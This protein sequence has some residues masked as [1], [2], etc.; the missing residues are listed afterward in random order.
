MPPTKKGKQK[1]E[2]RARHQEAEHDR[3]TPKAKYSKDDE[4]DEDEGWFTDKAPG[5][6]GGEEPQDDGQD[7][8]DAGGD[9]AGGVG[10][11]GSGIP[12]TIYAGHHGWKVVK[13]TFSKIFFHGFPNKNDNITNSETE[14]K[15]VKA[16]HAVASKHFAEVETHWYN[17]PLDQLVMYVDK[18]QI[19][20]YA[21][22]SYGMRVTGGAV[23]LSNWTILNDSVKTTGGVT[24][25]IVVPTNM[26]WFMIME[27]KGFRMPYYKSSP[28]N[29]EGTV[30][31]PNDRAN[32]ILS[33]I[34]FVVNRPGKW[35]EADYRRLTEPT[36]RPDVTVR[37]MHCS[38]KKWSTSWDYEEGWKL[39]V[40]EAASA[41]FPWPLDPRDVDKVQKHEVD[42]DDHNGYPGWWTTKDGG[43][44]GTLN[45]FPTL[46]TGK[47][48][49]GVGMNQDVV[50]ASVRTTPGQPPVHVPLMGSNLFIGRNLAHGGQKVCNQLPRVAFRGPPLQGVDNK[51]HKLLVTFLAKY[52]IHMEF[53]VSPDHWPAGDEINYFP[54][55][56]EDFHGSSWMFDNTNAA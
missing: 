20:K 40:P 16:D 25:P 8:V 22:T 17:L 34:T 45:T 54:L 28:C 30:P 35:D 42:R 52:T 3:E 2:K 51:I 36:Q 46:N 53:L 49:G 38:S 23:E 14:N 9:G 39:L 33:P 26:P 37:T 10:I 29:L 13:A 31:F 5:K 50:G 12:S 48:V 32:S 43:T 56:V 27:D 1:G 15:Y 4:S 11:A 18:W 6:K 21:K 55:H 44:L 19:E 41:P 47:L 24:E 7:A